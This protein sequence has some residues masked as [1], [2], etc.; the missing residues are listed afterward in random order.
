MISLSKRL[1]ELCLA[2]I[3]LTILHSLPPLPRAT[4]TR[5]ARPL[6]VLLLIL[7]HIDCRP[8]FF[9]TG[10]HKIVLEKEG[11]KL[12][13][14]SGGYH[15]ASSVRSVASSG[16]SGGMVRARRLAQE[17]SSLATSLPLSFSSSVFVRCDKERLDVMKVMGLSISESQQCWMLKSF[18]RLINTIF[19]LIPLGPHNRSIRHALRQ[20]MLRI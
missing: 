19:D 9:S 20:W 12:E 3:S 13:F 6:N 5:S 7:L 1:A 14:D 17:V 11:G 15:F 8:S 10:T 16:G 18:R 2:I 4:R